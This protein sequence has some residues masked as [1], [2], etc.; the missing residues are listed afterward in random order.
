MELLRAITGSEKV[1]VVGHSLGGVLLRWYV[2]ELGGDDTVDTAV[3]IASP[4]EG[5]ELARLVVGPAPAPSARSPR[6]RG[7]C[8]AWPAAPG[9]CRVRWIAYYSNLDVLVSRPPRP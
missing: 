1:H 7:S 4:H 2:Q 8:A 9:P 5:T 3:T 6:A